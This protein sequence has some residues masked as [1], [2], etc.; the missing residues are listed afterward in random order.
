MPRSERTLSND[1][2]LVGDLLGEVIRAHGGADLFDRVERM[3]QTAKTA[4]ESENAEE[5]ER[6]R[7][8]LAKEAAACGP[9][10]AIDVI[11]AFT[12]YFQLVNLCEDVHRTR[13]LRRRE[14]EHGAESIGGS[15]PAVVAELAGG[16]ATREQIVQAIEA[17]DLCFV[18]T[19]HPTEARRRTTE[20]LLAAARRTLEARDRHLLT[21]SE[22]RLEDRRLRAAIEALWE[23]APDRSERPEPIDEVKAGLWY[24]RH[25]LL[26]VV[27]SVARGLQRA[28]ETSF[29]R[30]D[31]LELPSLVRFGSWMGGDRDGNP[32]VTAAVT[33]RAI[34]FAR[35][36]I[37][38]RYEE[39]LEALID[40]LAGTRA[41][42]HE[43]ATLSRA[44]E[45][46]SDQVP[47]VAAT[48]NRRNKDEPLR[49]FLTLVY[50]RVERT[51]TS[52]AGAYATPDEFLDDLL[53]IRDV[54]LAAHATALADDLI[55]DLIYR[56]R[57]FGFVLATLDVREDA[58]VHRKAIAELL[59]DPAYPERSDAERIA[60]LQR[61]N[62]PKKG[63]AISA[64]TQRWLDLFNGLRR[65]L[66]RFGDEPLGAYVVTMTESIADVLEVKRVAELYGIDRNLDFVPLF[67][68]RTALQ[69]AGAIVRGLLD[70]ADYR[71]HVGRRGELQEILVGYS[72]SMKEAGILSSRALLLAAQ[73]EARAACDAAKV[74]LR[75][76]HGRG[77]SLSRGGGPTDRGIRALPAD[78]F[79]A[80]LKITEQGETRAA[81]FA[82]PDLA[83]RYLEQTLGAVLATEVKPHRDQP[84]ILDQLA[85][86]SYAA[87]RELVGD[88]ALLRFFWET[89]PIEAIGAMN[90]GSRPAKRGKDAPDSLADLRAIPWVFAWSQSRA[91]ITGWY[92]VG[93]ALEAAIAEVGIDALRELYRGSP[94]VRDLFDNVQM[95]LAKTDLPI[96]QRYAKLSTDAEGGARVFAKIA[97]ELERTKARLLE[98]SGDAELLAG[99]PVIQRSIRL[100]N[101]YVDP[102]SYLQL[103][104]L[105]RLRG[106]QDQNTR[107]TWLRVT[108]AAVQ[109]VAA[110]I[111]NTG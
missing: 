4:R 40:H 64:E 73:R 28:L 3:R 14:L 37:L 92:G 15:L 44:I 71:A 49:L 66:V 10:E 47:E 104:A 48:A 30:W 89:T 11:R 99:D 106:A 1:I 24:L 17:I 70:D 62:L 77:G 7:Q 75:V 80:D 84:P 90:I 67:E 22:E 5:C 86:H 54:L 68:S 36:I 91:V 19:A 74:R 63:A 46:S 109:G 50:T 101:P 20:R 60:A 43:S 25:V 102:L 95:T 93:S 88:P 18:F 105:A 82:N 41:R 2:R 56:V 65:I 58:R 69:R 97:E 83:A 81:H 78:A 72:D 29:G 100:R 34:E 6:A 42:L 53:I 98:I 38:H 107:D 21:P 76:F 110:G 96:A 108:K 23:H 31:P 94:F 52:A 103:E 45:R 55:L 111:R 85:E 79:A 26:E 27:P 87:Y 33:E 16:G 57:C 35:W 51:R 13:E 32:F 12:L 9:E 39:D 59:G 61:L 8:E